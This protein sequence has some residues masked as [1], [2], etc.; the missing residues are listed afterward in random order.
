MSAIL[1]NTVRHM[2]TQAKRVK[3]RRSRSLPGLAGRLFAAVQRSFARFSYGLAQGRIHRAA[4]ERELYQGRYRHSSK[5]DD[6][7]PIVR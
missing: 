4:I 1:L 2:S 6:D 5:C 3:T 7:L